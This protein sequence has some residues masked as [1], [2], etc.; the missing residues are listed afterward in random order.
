MIA[1]LKILQQFI[2]NLKQ[3]DNG[4]RIRYW[5]NSERGDIISWY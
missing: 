4:D 1:T 2:E 5:A 3:M